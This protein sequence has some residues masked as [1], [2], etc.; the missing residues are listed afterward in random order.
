VLIGICIPFF[1]SHLPPCAAFLPPCEAYPHLLVRL[2]V[3]FFPQF[4]LSSLF[5][6]FSL[7]FQNIGVSSANQLVFTELLY[8]YSVFLPFGSLTSRIPG[9]ICR[10]SDLAGSPCL[11]NSGPPWPLHEVAEW[12]GRAADAR[13]KRKGKQKEEGV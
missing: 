1:L 2:S 9:V 5:L 13:G 6:S 3:G 8:R 4:S 11:L 10:A 7:K 12:K